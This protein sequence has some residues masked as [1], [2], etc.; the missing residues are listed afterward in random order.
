[1][2]AE[3]HA[4]AKVVRD[5]IL[6]EA[7]DSVAIQSQTILWEVDTQRDFM[8]P[9]G[10]LYVPR[11]ERLI[12]NLRKLVDLARAN[13]AFLISSACQHTPDDP[14]FKV[15]PPHCVRGTPGAQLVPEAQTQKL[16]TVP[17]DPHFTL[18][19]DLLAYEQVLIEKQTL[20]VF[21]N[22]RTAAIVDLFPRNA[23]FLIF[24]VVTEYCVRCAANGLLDRGR[25]AAIVVDAI[26]TLKKEV[27]Q[28]TTSELAARGARLVSTE[29][30]LAQMR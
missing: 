2:A 22:P 23:E 3:Q 28:E 17:N 7:S 19:G 18:P 9:G 8:L 15:F 27:G 14:E 5:P 24:G 26:E 13:R 6:Q 29:E 20:D 4:Y 1:L 10:A 21:Q 11:A 30:V 12:P 25:R 16:F